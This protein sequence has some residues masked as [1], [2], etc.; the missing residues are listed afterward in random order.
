[1]H[2]ELLWSNVSVLERLISERTFAMN[3]HFERVRKIAKNSY[4]LPHAYFPVRP[5]G[6]NSSPTARIF[7]KFDI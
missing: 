3:A 4:S 5:H 1:M 6:P 2:A 7:T